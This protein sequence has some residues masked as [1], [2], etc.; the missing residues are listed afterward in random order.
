MNHELNRTTEISPELMGYLHIGSALFFVL[1][2]VISAFLLW[3]HPDLLDWARD[4]DKK[5]SDEDD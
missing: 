2:L 3:A 4:D 5:P 1:T